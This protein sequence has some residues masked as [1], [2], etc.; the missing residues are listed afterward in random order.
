MAKPARLLILGGT[1]EALALARQTVEDPR[2]TV[3]SSLAGRTQAPK[4]PPGNSRVGGFGGIAGLTV[5]LQQQAIDLVVDATHPFAERVSQHAAVACAAAEVPRLVLL[6]PPWSPQDGDRWISVADGAQ[7]AASL[8]DLG[9]RVFL[10]VGRQDLG[11]YEGLREHWFL[12]RMID[13]PDDPLALAKHEIVIGR[14]PFE[15]ASERRLLETHEIEAL[16]SKNSGGDA[17]YAKIAA[18]RALGLP[19]VMIERPPPPPGEP[20]SSVEETVAWLE[21]HLA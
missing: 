6:R 2:L 5:F 19:V 18:A 3:L 21:Q 10:T 20:V 17:T 9:Q 7:A 12:V 14:G 13:P 11:P 8:E 1:M 16:V 15:E 4:P